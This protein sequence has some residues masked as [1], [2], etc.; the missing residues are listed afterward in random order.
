M[1]PEKHTQKRRSERWKRRQKHSKIFLLSYVA[2][3]AL[4]LV[5]VW[6][7]MDYHK[8]LKSASRYRAEL[9]SAAEIPYPEDAETEKQEER[10]TLLA[11]LL[12]YEEEETEAP[13]GIEFDA[14]KSINEDVRAWLVLPGAELSEV[15]VQGRDNEKYLSCLLDGEQNASGTLFMDYRNAADFS[16]RMTIIYGHN[17]KD[18]SMFGELLSFRDP[19]YLEKHPKFLLYLP[20]GQYSLEVVDSFI[21]DAWDELYDLKDRFPEEGRLV[22]LSTC[23]YEGEESRFIVVT[24]MEEKDT[25]T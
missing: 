9:L 22:L 5:F 23:A 17:M 1:Q 14:L 8:G 18:G 21:T 16:D 24:R 11:E 19:K 6:K 3:C 4:I 25:V 13:M 10:P 7:L 20:N 15:V 2:I 12:D